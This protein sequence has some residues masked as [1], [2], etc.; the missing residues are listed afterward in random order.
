MG[1][2]YCLLVVS[3]AVQLTSGLHVQ[4]GG[5]PKNWCVGETDTVVKTGAVQAKL[6]TCTD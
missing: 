6:I 1:F 4:I 5:K 3:R 2:I